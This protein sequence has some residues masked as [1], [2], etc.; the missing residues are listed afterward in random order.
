MI[1]QATAIVTVTSNSES[2]SDNAS[3]DDCYE[4]QRQ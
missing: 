4:Q 2:N 1:E 3:N